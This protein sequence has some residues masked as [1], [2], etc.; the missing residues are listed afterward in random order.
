MKK[1]IIPF[2]LFVMMALGQSAMAQKYYT[3]DGDKFSVLLTADNG[4]TKITNVEFSFN[5]EWVKFKITDFANLEETN[6]GGFL[7]TVLDGN[8]KEFTVDYYRSGDKII[9]TNSSTG[10]QWTLY[11]RQE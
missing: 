4:N 11:R 8:G 5:G 1:L 7:Y 9:V 3:Y 10:D 2:V 6:E